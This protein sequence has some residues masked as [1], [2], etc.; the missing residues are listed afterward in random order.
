M[1]RSVAINDAPVS[2]PLDDRVPP[3]DAAHAVGV[4]R[5]VELVGELE[6]R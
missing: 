2:G 6:E 1:H 4:D 5:L 3:K